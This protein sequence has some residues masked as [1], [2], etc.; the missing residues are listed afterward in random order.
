MRFPAYLGNANPFQRRHGNFAS[1]RAE[2]DMKVASFPDYRWV[3]Y[4][5]TW[6]QAILA[7]DQRE[8]CGPVLCCFSS[9]L[10]VRPYCSSTSAVCIK[11]PVP[12][13]GFPLSP[14]LSPVI[15]DPLLWA[16]FPAMVLIPIVSPKD[17]TPAPFLNVS[18]SD[19]STESGPLSKGLLC[20]PKD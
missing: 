7:V 8:H 16:H 9:Q 12:L 4:F 17:N 1:L 11:H 3:Q 10:S 15:L 18:S 13:R 6:D 2:C 20:P 14:P 5:L 19:A